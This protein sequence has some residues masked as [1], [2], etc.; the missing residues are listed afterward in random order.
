[1]AIVP[2]PDA[3]NLTRL[4]AVLCELDAQQIGVDTQALPHRATDPDGL[5]RRQL[6]ARHCPR[7]AR[8]AARE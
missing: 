8:R 2:D 4:A 5:A 6:P 1:M 3:A 7:P